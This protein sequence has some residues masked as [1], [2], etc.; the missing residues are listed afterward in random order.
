MQQPVCLLQLKGDCPPAILVATKQVV[1]EQQIWLW[2]ACCDDMAPVEGSHTHDNPFA[3]LKQRHHLR[4]LALP[5]ALTRL[6]C[7]RNMRKM[8]YQ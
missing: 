8:V 3:C 2:R 6:S 1:S 4:D 7:R 5:A